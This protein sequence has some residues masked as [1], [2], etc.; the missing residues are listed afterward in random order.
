MDITRRTADQVRVP[1]VEAEQAVV[2]TRHGKDV[3]VVISTEDFALLQHLKAAIVATR[4]APFVYSAASLE[5]MR[6]DDEEI[7]DEEWDSMSGRP[8]E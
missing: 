5:A 8:A 1:R 3:A 6:D 4:P 7:T 2:V